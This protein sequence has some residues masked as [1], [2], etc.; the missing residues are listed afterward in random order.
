MQQ[1]TEGLESNAKLDGSWLCEC[2][3]LS[4][5]WNR[6]LHTNHSICKVVQLHVMSVICHTTVWYIV[7][8][9]RCQQAQLACSGKTSDGWSDA[10]NPR[11][12]Q[13]PSPIAI[14]NPS[15]YCGASGA[16]RN[17]ATCTFVKVCRQSVKQA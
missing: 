15:P 3:R 4:R 2:C 8:V 7:K 9:H 14:Y 5:L 13:L 1:L 6:P 16:A 11:N 17:S 10:T 12:A